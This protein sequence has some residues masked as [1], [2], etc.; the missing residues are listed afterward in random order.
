MERRYDI[1]YDC[2]NTPIDGT[3]VHAAGGEKAHGR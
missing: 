2:R 3:A 1:G